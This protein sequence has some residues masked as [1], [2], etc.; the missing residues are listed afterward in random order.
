[1]RPGYVL[2]AT[3]STGQVILQELYYSRRKAQ[4]A[5]ERL[6]EVSPDGH[7]PLLLEDGR[8]GSLFYPAHDLDIKLGNV[9]RLWIQRNRWKSS[10]FDTSEDEFREIA[11]A[12]DVPIEALKK[13]ASLE[14][15]HYENIGDARWS[16]FKRACLPR[17][18][19]GWF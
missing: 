9:D 18:M 13:I 16:A 5:F 3:T 17:F 11:E 10:F 8:T 15:E 6:H 12:N 2:T 1:M 19:Y 14:R 4:T 7:R